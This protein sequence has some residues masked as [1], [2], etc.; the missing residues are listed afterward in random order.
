MVGIDDD[1]T[2]GAVVL[3]REELAE[4]QVESI[5]QL[6]VG[7][8]PA[9]TR[10]GD[11]VDLGT[12]L[13]GLAASPEVVGA[14]LQAVRAWLARRGRGRVEIQVGRDKLLLDNASPEQQQQL[15]DAFVDR[16]LRR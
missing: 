2:A 10:A 5:R 16:A 9:G 14:T 6:P 13:V 8:A 3:L 15:I 7:S 1:D 12:V 4:L 11:L